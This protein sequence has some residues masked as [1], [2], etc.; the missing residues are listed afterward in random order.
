MNRS[1]FL[2]VYPGL[3]DDMFTFVEQAMEE[4]IGNY[5]SPSTGEAG[6]G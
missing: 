5:S 1:F 6:R 3:T 4:F 2:G